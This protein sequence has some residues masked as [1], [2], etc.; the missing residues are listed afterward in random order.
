MSQCQAP[1]GCSFFAP[2]GRIYCSQHFKLLAT[3]EQ[4]AAANAF[5]QKR[6]EEIRQAKAAWDSAVDGP[7]PE[8]HERLLGV[9]EMP[10]YNPEWPRQDFLKAYQTKDI[11]R[12]YR[13]NQCEKIRYRDY[14]AFPALLYD[15]FTSFP[16]VE[17]THPIYDQVFQQLCASNTTL[18]PK[19]VEKYLYCSNTHI[20]MLRKLLNLTTITRELVDAAKYS[21]KPPQNV[22]TPEK[23]A[24]VDLVVA[25]FKQQQQEARNTFG[26]MPSNNNGSSS[27]ST[28]SS[29]REQ[30]YL[31][32][33]EGNNFDFFELTRDGLKILYYYGRIDGPGTYIIKHFADERGARD[34]FESRLEEKLKNGFVKVKITKQGTELGKEDEE[35]EEPEE[36]K[37]AKT[38]S[39]GSKRKKSGSDEDEDE[40]DD[41]EDEDEDEDEIAAVPANFSFAPLSFAAPSFAAPSFAAPNFAPPTKGPPAFAPPTT[42]PAASSG[43]KSY[44]ECVE[45]GSSKF[46]EITLSGT[47]VNSRYGKIGTSG[48]TTSK[49][50]DTVEK[51]KAFYDKTLKEK[52]SK[53][54]HQA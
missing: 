45:G 15:L 12:I 49:S 5:A 32:S 11:N 47:E 52:M 50:F 8:A 40:E 53:G 38:M 35:K 3:E 54:Y 46:Y 21:I 30:V 24:M 29:N 33:L 18:E 23:K 43:N 4:K 41:D 39:S 26:T 20:E 34:F 31:E 7:I 51:A 36:M 17:W 22:S 48:Q 14:S 19:I 2:E 28:S 27:S 1:D 42:G 10:G 9:M 25:T 6:E 44:L 16:P 13:I 37:S